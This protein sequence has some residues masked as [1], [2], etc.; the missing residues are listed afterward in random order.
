MG[1]N[2]KLI[3]DGTVIKVHDETKARLKAIGKMGDTYDDVL[4]RLMDR[5]AELDEHG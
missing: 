2:G 4:N 1:R 5:V 3:R